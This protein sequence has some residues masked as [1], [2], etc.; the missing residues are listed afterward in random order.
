MR[1]IDV[2]AAQGP[3]PADSSRVESSYVCAKVITIVLLIDVTAI[4]LVH[5]ADGP[6]PTDYNQPRPFSSGPSE[7]RLCRNGVNKP[8]LSSQEDP[9]CGLFMFSA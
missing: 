7:S 8:D 4:T 1:Q 9:H 2:L 5:L 6:L 3:A